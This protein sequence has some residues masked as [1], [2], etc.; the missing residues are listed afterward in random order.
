MRPGDIIPIQ[1]KG[2]VKT[3]WRLGKILEVFPDK[4]GVVRTCE[5]GYRSRHTGE[6]VMPYRS[7]P[8]QTLRIAVQRLCVLLPVE[9]QL[10]EENEAAASLTKKDALS[11]AGDQSLAEVPE[12]E[13]DCQVQAKPASREVDEESWNLC[14]EDLGTCPRSME[15]VDKPKKL[16]KRE[17]K[18]SSKQ[19]REP[20]R[21]S[22]RLAG[23]SA[24]IEVALDL[25]YYLTSEEEDESH[26]K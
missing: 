20:R 6:K 10:T 18:E 1:Y 8:L 2:R 25:E 23:F 4:H 5:V 15:E 21:F 19:L 13:K 9:E 22:R 16:S 12:A 3:I 26:G 14:E 11:E 7:R 24:A 17:K